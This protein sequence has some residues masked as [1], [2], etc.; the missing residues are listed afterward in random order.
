[1]PEDV[2]TLTQAVHGVIVVENPLRLSNK[3]ILVKLLKNDAVEATMAGQRTRIPLRVGN[4]VPSTFMEQAR[5][6]ARDV[7]KQ[8]LRPRSIDRRSC[9]E[10]VLDILEDTVNPTRN[11][12]DEPE[13]AV[14]IREV[15]RPDAG[16][17]GNAGEVEA[18][19]QPSPARPVH[20]VARLVAANGRHPLKS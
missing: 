15:R 18:W 13:L 7:K 8:R 20:Q 19:K 2:R 14:R 1:M 10:V 12:V 9:N 16:G 4:I 17:V 11:G 6:K 3:A 5:V